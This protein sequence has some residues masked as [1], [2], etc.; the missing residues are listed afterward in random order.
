MTH[1]PNK[2]AAFTLIELLV[3]IAII[4]ILA[5][6]LLPAL[7]RAKERARA[8]QCMN[9]GRQMM[10]GFLM[11]PSDYNDLLLGALGGVPMNRVN[12][13]TGELDFD[14][15]NLSNT[16]PR[17]D[18]AVSP[19][20]QY[21]GQNYTVWRCPAD[22]IFINGLPRVR[23]YSMSQAFSNGQ[24]LPAPPYVVPNLL[25]DINTPAA[26]FCILDEHP[27]SI[28]DGGL[29]TQMYIPGNGAA[30]IIDFPASYHNGACGIGFAD[31]HSEIHKWIG[32]TIQPPINMDGALPL[33]GT[34]AGDSTVDVAWLSSVTGVTSAS[35]IQSR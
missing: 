14:P 12:W 24:W 2:H 28:N 21:I 4:A 18:L 9:N 13:V 16:D 17:V 10:L 30:E 1:R 3:V 6:L 29:A 23:S 34:A 33:N 31:G 25:T 7:A 20:M 8:I 32:R 27:D 22:P 11:Y 15:S 19:L 26:M 5:G 35:V